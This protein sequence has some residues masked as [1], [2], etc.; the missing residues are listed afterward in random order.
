MAL[1]GSLGATRFFNTSLLGGNISSFRTEYGVVSEKEVQIRMDRQRGDL[2]FEGK[3]YDWAKLLR[4]KSSYTQYRHE[5]VSSGKV[6][7]LFKNRGH[8]T[9]LEMHHNDWG[10]VHGEFGLHY[11]TQ[12]M[13]VEGDEAFLPTTTS[14]TSALYLTEE[15]QGQVIRPNWGIRGEWTTIE[16][17]GGAAFGSAETKA[18][19]SASG[20]VGINTTVSGGVD[21]PEGEQ[22]LFANLTATQRPPNAQ[23]LFAAGPHIATQTFENGNRNLG[24]EQ[25]VGLEL[26]LRSRSKLGLLNTVAFV[27]Q[28][29]N[30]LAL[31]PTG[32][33]DAGSNLPIFNFEAS[34]AQLAGA[35]AELRRT[36]LR[37]SENPWLGSGVVDLV[38]HP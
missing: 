30:Y 16:S 14:S 18:F 11:Q 37:A 17:A 31:V 21:D 7:T 22:T 33:T 24:L 3:K 29:S 2:L 26:G 25:G 38:F 35:E 8:E 4:L 23:E 5:E 1:D 15:L 13:E 10:P 36:V 32:N 27:Q 34:K 28:F 6:E 9:R 12:R 20:S 19:G